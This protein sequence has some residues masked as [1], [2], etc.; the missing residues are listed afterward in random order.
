MGIGFRDDVNY[1]NLDPITI[2]PQVTDYIDFSNFVPSYV[3]PPPPPA[4]V[5][6][7]YNNDDDGGGDG[8]ETP[9]APAGYYGD[10]MNSNDQ[11]GAGDQGSPGGHDASGGSTSMGS[12]SGM[13]GPGDMG[14]HDSGADADGNDAEGEGG[15]WSH[16]GT[17]P[18]MY[19]YEGLTKQERD[20]AAILAQQE[21]AKPKHTFDFTPSIPSLPE[22][23]DNVGYIKD[24]IFDSAFKDAGRIPE[25]LG[26]LMTDNFTATVDNPILSALASLSS[27]AATKAGVPAVGAYLVADAVKK[28]IPQQIKDNLNILNPFDNVMTQEFYDAVYNDGNEYGYSP[29]ELEAINQAPSYGVN[30]GTIPNIDMTNPANYNIKDYVGI[31]D[32]PPTY[33]AIPGNYS[34]PN[35]TITGTPTYNDFV[36]STPEQFFEDIQAEL[37]A[38]AAETGSIAGNDGGGGWA[39]GGYYND[40]GTDLGTN[41]YSGGDTPSTGD[42]IADAM[43]DTD[44]FGLSK[45]GHIYA[46]QGG[47]VN[48]T[49]GK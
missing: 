48:S 49:G 31:P 21:A 19:A 29:D 32:T 11:E 5:Y 41:E 2:G 24:N 4:P 15:G 7:P 8:P 25:N 33:G 46:S 16:G 36:A 38:I 3:P 30:I 12:N 28:N 42:A 44:Q 35:A 9:D 17:I 27:A 37:A 14:G 23:A 13:S 43:N 47:Y 26:T 6:N 20:R 45:G 34:P 40:D 1:F 22:L 10:S 39:D 18:P